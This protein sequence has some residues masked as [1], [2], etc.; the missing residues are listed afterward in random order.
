MLQA[1]PK[2]AAYVAAFST[3]TTSETAVAKALAGEI[4]I[5]G[6]LPVTI[7]PFAKYGDGIERAA[8]ATAPDSGSNVPK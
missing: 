7:P 5:R 2:V 3:T 1:F 6:K 8:R 4:A